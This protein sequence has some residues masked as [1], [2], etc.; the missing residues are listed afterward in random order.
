MSIVENTLD[1]TVV[2]DDLSQY[3]QKVLGALLPWEKTILLNES[4]FGSSD[5]APSGME[6]FTIAHEIGHW[7]LHVNH[8]CLEQIPLFDLN[9]EQIICR[10]GDKDV[11]EH[12]ANRFAARIL[13]PKQMLMEALVAVDISQRSEYR[14]FADY[15]GVSREALHY[16][17][18][19]LGIVHSWD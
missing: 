16:R 14:Q 4:F 6:N 13:M 2:Y 1:L 15:I 12:T 19:D 5:Q 3:G 8:S 7:I 9:K 17:L 11:K 10:D 18:S